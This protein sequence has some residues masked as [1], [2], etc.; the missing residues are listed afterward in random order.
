MRKQVKRNE[1]ELQEKVEGIV[2]RMGVNADGGKKRNRNE[3]YWE[4][5]RSLRMW[6]ITGNNHQDAVMTFL[7]KRLLMSL[8]NKINLIILV[9]LPSL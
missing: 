1:G 8:S 3:R 9:L 6:P 4:A 2:G 5:R 7:E